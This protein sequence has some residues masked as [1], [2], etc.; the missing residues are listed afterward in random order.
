MDYFVGAGVCAVEDA[1]LGGATVTCVES[2]VP[3][4]AF[5]VTPT[6]SATARTKDCTAVPELATAVPCFSTSV[7]KAST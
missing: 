3:Y 6:L 2:H 5:T 1:A 7:V 4:F